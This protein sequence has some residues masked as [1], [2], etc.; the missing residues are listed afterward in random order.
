MPR[1]FTV[2]H[3]QHLGEQVEH[4]GRVALGGHFLQHLAAQIRRQKHGAGQFLRVGGA[5]LLVDRGQP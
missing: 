5:D 3:A 1:G 2:G 4:G